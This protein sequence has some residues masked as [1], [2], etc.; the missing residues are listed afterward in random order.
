MHF[1]TS[2]VELKSCIKKDH[3]LLLHY[4]YEKDQLL[5]ATSNYE[6]SNIQLCVKFDNE[7]SSLITVDL[8]I[9][10]PQLWGSL[11]IDE[12]NA[13]LLLVKVVENGV[14]M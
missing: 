2:L 8:S 1:A 7:N 6:E 13:L 11:S 12:R 3:A 4:V 5:K 9:S 10:D 14:R